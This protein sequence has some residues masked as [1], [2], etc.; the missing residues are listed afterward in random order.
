MRHRMKKGRL[1]RRTSWR[2]AT[3]KSMANDL[4]TY[5]RIETTLVKA[6]ALR[7]FAE[8]LI[9]LAKKNPESVSARRKAFQKLCDK[10]V[11]KSLFD[12][13]GPLYKDINGGYT[14]IMACGNRRGDGAE[15]AIIELT[16]RTISDDDLLGRDK[17]KVDKKDKAKT[18]KKAGAKTEDKKEK[19]AAAPDNVSPE[20]K[21]K[22]FV[23]DVRKE[24]AK[25]E[26][27][28]VTDKGLFKR[29]R[30]KS[31]G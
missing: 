3:L 17:V 11:V 15:M 2:K 9:T 23:E 4:F 1:N 31:I 13:I 29:F 8:P 22:R 19:T 18:S 6:K 5:Q 16:K 24:K 21:E 28:K 10:T 14:R 7:G 27:R 30:R 26:Q 12:A 20:E 25:K